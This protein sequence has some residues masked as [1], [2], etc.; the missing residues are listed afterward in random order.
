VSIEQDH[1]EFPL[2]DTAIGAAAAAAEDLPYVNRELSWLDFN[3]RV[4][5]L[6][7]DPGTPLLERVKFLTIFAGNLDEFFMIRVAGLHDQ[8]DAGLTEP[9]LCGRT[10]SEIIDEI[11]DRVAGLQER[12]T[13]LV[14][15]RL[16]P[17][18]AEHGI[19]ITSVGDL[20]SAARVKIEENFRGR[21]QLDAEV[22]PKLTFRADRCAAR[23]DGRF[24]VTG[25]LTIHGVSRPTTVVMDID[26]DGQA[27]RA[28]GR[29]VAEHGDF[30]MKPFT[31]ALGAVRNAAP[32]TFGIDLRGRVR[33]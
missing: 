21:S 4:L 19:R 18:L 12:Q 10:P 16:L 8:V 1:E 13:E 29:L 5:Q 24:D 9:K 22:F 14:G 27:F 32:L 11:R 3:D 2:V 6:A 28:R 26:A 33:E 15:K 7:E 23:A 20:P 30:G 25:P 31:A 17:A